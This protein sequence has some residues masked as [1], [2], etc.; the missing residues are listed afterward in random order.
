L[1]VYCVIYTICDLLKEHICDEDEDKII[2]MVFH[3][4]AEKAKIL[5]K[6]LKK[7]EEINKADSI[8]HKNGENVSFLE[9][10]NKLFKKLEGQSVEK[11]LE[12][13]DEL[14]CL[15]LPCLKN[16]LNLNRNKYQN[17]FHISEDEFTTLLSTGL[18]SK[19]I[20]KV[21]R[22]ILPGVHYVQCRNLG[23]ETQ[24][25]SVTFADGGSLS[26]ESTYIQQDTTFDYFFDK[27]EEQIKISARK[28]FQKCIQSLVENPENLSN[29]NFWKDW[30]L[31]SSILII[32]FEVFS[33]IHTTSISKLKG[34][35]LF[36]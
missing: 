6:C 1:N 16:V 15:K 8:F 13:K 2:V 22:K 23:N 20:E 14:N 19:T 36:K 21:C 27:L 10:K 9:S 33:A 26:V 34:R 24:V 18:T 30:N 11:L 28:N 29:T 35:V 31:P 4:Q 17:L 12:M 5:Q 25:I 7:L 32:I 3:E